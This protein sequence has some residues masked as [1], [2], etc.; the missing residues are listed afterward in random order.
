MC[1]HWSHMRMTCNSVSTD[2]SFHFSFLASQVSKSPKLFITSYFHSTWACVLFCD[3]TLITFECCW[4][5]YG[6]LQSWVSF[7]PLHALLCCTLCQRYTFLFVFFYFFHLHSPLLADALIQSGLL[8]SFVVSGF[9]KMD[10]LCSCSVGESWWI[11]RSLLSRQA[12]G[13]H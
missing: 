10:D 11:G 2:Q 6:I 4:A 3:N 5:V 7:Y 9:L 13:V 1:N 12:G 8:K